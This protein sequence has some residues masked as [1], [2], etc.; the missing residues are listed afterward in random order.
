MIFGYQVK[1]PERYGV[2]E[3]SEDLTVLSLEEKPKKDVFELEILSFFKVEAAECL[4]HCG[5]LE[6]EK[7]YERAMS[8]LLEGAEAF[9]EA[10]G[11]RMRLGILAV[12]HYPIF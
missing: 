6:N 1:D 7:K 9:R 4:L 11:P 5:E 10:Q 3:F 12:H 8:L 2:V